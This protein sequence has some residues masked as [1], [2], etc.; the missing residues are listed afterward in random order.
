M[1]L[2][3][4]RTRPEDEWKTQAK[5]YVEKIDPSVFDGVKVTANR[6]DYSEAKAICAQCPVR[7][8]C[9]A[10]AIQNEESDCVRGGM[11][12]DEYRA[13]MDRPGRL[14]RRKRPGERGYRPKLAAAR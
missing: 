6:I 10:D 1:T 9:L 14:V 12:P 13:L 5:C 11:T 7:D 3:Q 2:Y 8:L 4:I